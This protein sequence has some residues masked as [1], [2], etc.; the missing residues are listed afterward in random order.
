M[1]TISG[2]NQIEEGKGS[3]TV[4][5]PQGT[6][7]DIEAAIFAPRATRNLISFRD[8]VANKYQLRTAKINELE[9]LQIL[10]DTNEGIKIK[11]SLPFI[12]PGLYAAQITANYATTEASDIT[13]MALSAWTPW[14]EHV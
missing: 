12:P 1:T 7:I 9:T 3:A 8:V 13:Y 11:E 6:V 5:F 4:I 2:T 14:S 10:E